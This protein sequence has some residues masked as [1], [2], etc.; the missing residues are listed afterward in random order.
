MVWR[1]VVWCGVV[2]IVVVFKVYWGDAKEKLCSAVVDAPLDFLVLGCRGLGAL[3]RYD[4]MP[5]ASLLILVGAL[6][7]E[8]LKNLGMFCGIGFL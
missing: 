6:I 3:K 1:G 8:L 4:C 5:V 7:R 2:Q